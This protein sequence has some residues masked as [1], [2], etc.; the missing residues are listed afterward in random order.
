MK[1][2]RRL[3]GI[4]ACAV[5][6]AGISTNASATV[7]GTGCIITG[8]TGQTAPTTG[9]IN[10]VS[11]FLAACATANGGVTPNFTFTAPDNVV[12]NPIGLGSA[13]VNGIL[14]APGT[15]VVCSNGTANCATTTATSGSAGSGPSAVSTWFDFQ[16]TLGT[17]AANTPLAV[18]LHDDGVSLY[19]N[20]VNVG[21]T[22]TLALPETTAQAAA[23]QSA[24]V[25][26][27]FVITPAMSGQ[28][29]DFIWDECCGNPGQLSVNLPGEAT[30]VPEPASIMLFGTV[31]AGVVTVLRRRGV[32]G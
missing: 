29:V 24:A 4:A 5:M 6:L 21:T 12:V 11:S 10:S 28:I 1:F 25:G 31:L 26:A 7:T 20:G 3:L 13:T 2:K 17:I 32:K 27:N 16:Y 18:T 23:P 19:V 14:A 15:N 8:L 22:P 9:T 30:G